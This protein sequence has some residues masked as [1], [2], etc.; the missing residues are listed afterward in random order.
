MEYIAAATAVSGLLYKVWAAWRESEEEKNENSLSTLAEASL[1]VGSIRG[2]DADHL[3]IGEVERPLELSQVG[4]LNVGEFRQGLDA[5]RAG[6]F[7]AFT[8]CGGRLA[9]HIRQ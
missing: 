6:T 1:E 3:L 9:L 2:A 4:G 7:K 5:H 8:C